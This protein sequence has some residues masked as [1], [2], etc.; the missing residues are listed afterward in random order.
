[1]EHLSSIEIYVL[2]LE[3]E[4]ENLQLVDAIFRPFHTIKGV[5]GFLNLREIN[6]LSHQIETVLDDARSKKIPVSPSLVDIVL[7]GVDLV[8]RLIDD[9]DDRLKTGRLEPEYIDLGPFLE[10]LRKVAEAEAPNLEDDEQ[11]APEGDGLDVGE[12][13]VKT[14]VVQAE[15]LEEAL[16]R[17]ASGESPGRKDR[18][19]SD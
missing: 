9:V 13:L 11:A 8:T 15:D 12:I 5:S 10:R 3:K 6:K 19:N 17:Q 4:P 14:G 18:R 7:D 1:M 2:E 16:A